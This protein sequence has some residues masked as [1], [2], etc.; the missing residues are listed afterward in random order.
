MKAGQENEFFA[1]VTCIKCQEKRQVPN[2]YMR[3][4]ISGDWNEKF[5]CYKFKLRNVTCKKNLSPVSVVESKPAAPIV[6]QVKVKA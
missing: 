4:Y 2:K 6:K 3:R 1:E 5:I